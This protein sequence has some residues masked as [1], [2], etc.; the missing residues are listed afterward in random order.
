MTAGEG[1]SMLH[2]F[3]SVSKHGNLEANKEKLII[4]CVQTTSDPENRPSFED[5]INRMTCIIPKSATGL[6]RRSSES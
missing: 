3:L 5:I 1:M 6:A 4:C 2:Y